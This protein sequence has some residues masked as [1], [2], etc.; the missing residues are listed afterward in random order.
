MLSTTIRRVALGFGV[1]LL[2]LAS[3]VAAQKTVQPPPDSN[4]TWKGLGEPGVDYEEICYQPRISAGGTEWGG[5]ICEDS[6]PNP[7]Q[8]IC[9]EFSNSSGD[10][11]RTCCISRFYEGS[12]VLDACMAN[13]TLVR[14]PQPEE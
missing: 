2:V 9:A 5:T 1:L 11:L 12:S 13:V 10:V 7:T 3:V 8:N 14:S 4:Y 6:C